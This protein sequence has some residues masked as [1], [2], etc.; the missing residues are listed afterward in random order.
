MLLRFGGFMP[1]IFISYSR[2]DE[3]FARQIARSLSNLGADIWL[4]VEDIPAGMNW[5]TAI[6]QGLNLCEVMIVII[7]PDSSASQN[8]EEEWQYYRDNSKPIVPILLK[9][10]AVHY[11]LS[12][13]QYVDFYKQDYDTA[14]GQ[15]HSELRRKGVQID[16]IS[17]SDTSVQIPDQAPL[18]IIDEPQRP[19]PKLIVIVGCF[20]SL[21]AIFSL[22]GLVAFL[23]DQASLRIT[24]TTQ[25]VQAPSGTLSGTD[26]ELTVQ[27]QMLGIQTEAAQT[28]QAQGTATVGMQTAFA[29][30]TVY[31]QG[32]RDAQATETAI[33]WTP[34]PTPDTRKTA[35]AR[36]TQTSEAVI[37]QATIDTVASAT[38]DARNQTATATLWTPTPTPTPRP[39]IDIPVNSNDQWQPLTQSFEGVDM[40]L[41]P[42]G[43]FMMGS[44]NGDTDERPIH[45]QCFDQPFWIDRTE[46]S[47]N[48][49]AT[50][51]GI[52]AQSS[53]WTRDIQPRE[54]IT[55][56]EA[57]DFCEKRDARLPTEAQW[58]YAARGP[59]SLVYP[60]GN[61]FV[62][63]N[64]AYGANSPGYTAEVISFPNGESWVGARN[65]SGNVWEWVN[66]LYKSYPY[67]MD[68]GN[69]IDT[70]ENFF[71]VLRGGSWVDTSSTLR[72]SE[73][74]TGVSST[75]RNNIGFR[76]ARDFQEGDLEGAQPA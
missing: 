23:A 36:L 72:T 61:E 59:D 56:F 66:S 42:M 37:A 62:A 51:N 68:D 58:E 14:F 2:V 44:E 39:G 73:R 29:Q 13:M 52:A 16:P 8:V 25:V 67:D 55:W 64:A 69:E 6:H 47:N 22:A 15:L 34:T 54:S 35:E 38:Q 10:T 60:W 74:N 46:V 31:A 33:L 26:I 45:Q 27:G 11:Q 3:P 49:F 20:V 24:P 30:Q 48:Q 17:V 9:P 71:R 19:R 76:C 5:S 18:P 21:A 65:M 32:T 1:R 4:D 57:R 63:G 28:A 75:H 50:F 41:V 53:N 12:R 70:N 43:C 40:V 7:T